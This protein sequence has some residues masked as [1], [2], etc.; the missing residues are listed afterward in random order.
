MDDKELE[1]ILEGAER[2]MKRVEEAYPSPT[3]WGILLYEGF[4]AL[5]QQNKAII[6]LLKDIYDKK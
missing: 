3:V 2:S 6:E 5:Y 4:N 1:K